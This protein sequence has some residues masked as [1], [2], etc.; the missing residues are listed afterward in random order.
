MCACEI[1]SASSA[2]LWERIPHHLMTCYLL[3]PNPS[4]LKTCLSRGRGIL[5]TFKSDDDEKTARKRAC[6]METG[7]FAERAMSRSE[8]PSVAAVLRRTANEA[9]NLHRVEEE[10]RE[11][12]YPNG[13]F[14]IEEAAEEEEEEEQAN[15]SEMSTIEE[16][17]EEDD[18]ESDEQESD[19]EESDEENE[20]EAGAGAGSNMENDQFRTPSPVA[21]VPVQ[22]DIGDYHPANPPVEFKFYLA[23]VQEKQNKAET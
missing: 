7:G 6:T 23:F 15:T 17:E 8:S 22:S 3:L 21:P 20:P 10:L 14:T 4:L 18:E 19:E 5:S 13:L 1:S 9:L 2:Y 16:D 12:F 11:Q